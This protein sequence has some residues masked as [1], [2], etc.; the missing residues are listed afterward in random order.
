MGE[1]ETTRYSFKQLKRDIKSDS[2]VSETDAEGQ[3]QSC[4]GAKVAPFF[5]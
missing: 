4:S 2:V 5:F 3:T 1:T